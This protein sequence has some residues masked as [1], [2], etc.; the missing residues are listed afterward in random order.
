MAFEEWVAEVDKTQLCHITVSMWVM[1]V[2]LGV[3]SMVTQGA[4]LQKLAAVSKVA[5]L[6][7]PAAPVHYPPV[8]GDPCLVDESLTIQY[9][10]SCESSSM[11]IFKDEGALNCSAE[12]SIPIHMHNPLETVLVLV[13]VGIHSHPESDQ[14]ICSLLV[15]AVKEAGAM[16]LHSEYLIPLVSYSPTDSRCVFLV[17]FKEPFLMQGEWNVVFLIRASMEGV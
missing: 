2:I 17:W 5:T 11:S 12:S 14:I 15:F 3:T 7:A 4:P 1:A 8:I 13:L 16:Y 10:C 6:V 9:F